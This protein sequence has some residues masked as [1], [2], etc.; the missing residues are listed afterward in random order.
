MRTHTEFVE[1]AT[2]PVLDLQTGLEIYD[3]LLQ[4]LPEND[5]DAQ[6]LLGEFHETVRDY[7]TIRGNWLLIS[8]EERIETDRSRTLHHD[9][10]ITHV[11]MMKRYLESIGADTS[12]LKVFEREDEKERRKLIGDFACIVYCLL[13]IEA[14]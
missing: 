12:F 10:M 13:G 2:Y 3:R 9:S 5:E 6:E 8:R 1:K 14:R 11:N 7:A 4:A